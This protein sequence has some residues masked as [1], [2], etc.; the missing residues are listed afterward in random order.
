LSVG[1][2]IDVQGLFDTQHPDLRVYPREA[3]EITLVQAATLAK[4]PV[5]PSMPDWT[6][7]G[8]AGFTVAA[9]EGIKRFRKWRREKKIHSLIKEAKGLS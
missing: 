6:P 8:A 9:A 4:K 1:D 5:T 2:V 3:S 7:I